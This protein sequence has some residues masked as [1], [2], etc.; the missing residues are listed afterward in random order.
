MIWGE[1]SLNPSEMGG[2]QAFLSEEKPD[3]ENSLPPTQDS[4]GK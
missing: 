3:K 2:N 1:I 4:R